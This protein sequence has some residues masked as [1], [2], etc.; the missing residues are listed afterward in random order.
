[1]GK[2]LMTNTELVESIILDLNNIPKE[3]I[4][5]QFI[6]FCTLVSQ[7]GNKLVALRQG[8][9]QDMDNKNETIEQLKNQLRECG[10][11]LEDMTPEEFIEKYGK[12]DGAE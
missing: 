3:L 2:G 11:E 7:I 10:A 9:K 1:M 5:G 8:I 6:G 12:K 4:D